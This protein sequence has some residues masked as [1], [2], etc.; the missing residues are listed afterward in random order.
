MND[1][2]LDI[3]LITFFGNTGIAI[4]AMTWANPMPL[5]GRL[6]TTFM[7]LGGLLG[8]LIRAALLKHQSTVADKGRAAVEVGAEDR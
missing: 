3:F 1:K 7:G 6:L 8:A 4:L 2:S 5:S